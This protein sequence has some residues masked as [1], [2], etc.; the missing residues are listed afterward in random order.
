[1]YIESSSPV[2]TNC[3]FLENTADLNGG[4]AIHSWNA[5]P[6]ITNSLFLGNDGG[7]NGG[8]AIFNWD[9]PAVTVTNC[10]FS[11]NEGGSSGGGAISNYNSWMVVTNCILWGDSADTG[12]EAYNEGGILTI[13]HCDLSGGMAGVVNAGGGTIND[14]GTNLESDPLFAAAYHLQAGSLCINAGDNA[15]LPPDITDL[16]NDGD[17]TEPIPLDLDG[18]PRILAAVVD[19]GAYEYGY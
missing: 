19:M 3:T 14:D 11:Q 7:S 4:G 10:T 9:C 12:S 15:A 13:S 2:V 6:I 8:G 17:T 16:D 5:S 1:M 18:G